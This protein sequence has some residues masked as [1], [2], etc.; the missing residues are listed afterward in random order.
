MNG[1][2]ASGI[3]DAGESGAATAVRT[4]E[5]QTG[6]RPTGSVE[7]LLSFQ[8]MPGMVDT[9]QE[10]YVVRGAQKVGE[11]ATPDHDIRIDWLPLGQVFELVR[12]GEVLGSASLVGL[13]YL[14][15]SSAPPGPVGKT[16]E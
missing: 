9:P 11:P 6:W 1:T 13:L 5:E 16:S 10:I 12:T 2:G 3:V 7:H 8:P 14:L 15:A 4:I